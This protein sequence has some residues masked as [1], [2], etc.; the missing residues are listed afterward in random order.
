[1][2]WLTWKRIELSGIVYMEIY[3]QWNNKKFRGG[4]LLIPREGGNY[5]RTSYTMEHNSLEINTTKAED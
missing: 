3:I 2:D 4:G 5:T 1:M